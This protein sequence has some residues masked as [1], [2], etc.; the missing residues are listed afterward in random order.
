M[1][2][3]IESEN[4]KVDKRA[5]GIAIFRF[6]TSYLAEK[7]NWTLKE[8]IIGTKKLSPEIVDL[9]LKRLFR[10]ALYS[11]VDMPL[12]HGP[13]LVKRYFH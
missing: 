3:E 1:R 4:Y 6:R 7:E 12:I 8:A 13:E 9:S 2:E 11:E 5:N 10:Q